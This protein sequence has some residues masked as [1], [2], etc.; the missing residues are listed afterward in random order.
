MGYRSDVGL[1]LTKT[2]KEALD[3]RLAECGS[4][5]EETRQI[6]RLLT[7]SG[8]RREDQDSGAVAWFWE[9]LKWYGDYSDVAFIEN[10][11]REL[12]DEEY[13][14]IRVGESDDDIEYRGGFQENPFGM[15]LMRG[16]GFD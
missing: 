11:L 4:N 14:F 1:C 5:T 3:T 8:N 9:S 12:D 7:S 10:L 13:F 15:C 16:I 6:R 2:G